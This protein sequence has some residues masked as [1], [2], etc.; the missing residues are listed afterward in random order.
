MSRSPCLGAFLRGEFLRDF[1]SFLQTGRLDAR[2]HSLQKSR[3]GR[4]RW[5]G[6]SGWGVRS[7]SPSQ[8]PSRGKLPQ[9]WRDLR[10]CRPA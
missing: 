7:S 8:E 4:R 5:F 1:P 3:G 2:R 9:G 10:G 6:V